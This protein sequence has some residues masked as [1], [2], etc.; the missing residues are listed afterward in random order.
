MPPAVELEVWRVPSA[1]IQ[2]DSVYAMLEGPPLATPGWLLAASVAGVQIAATTCLLLWVFLN[3]P[4]CTTPRFRE[5]RFDVVVA[6]EDAHRCVKMYNALIAS[7]AGREGLD[8]Q[9]IIELDERAAWRGAVH[10]MAG[11]ERCFDSMPQ[12]GPR[13]IVGRGV[14]GGVDYLELHQ[15][16]RARGPWRALSVAARRVAF[17]RERDR[18]VG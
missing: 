2:E 15:Q 8:Q 7:S 18:G 1:E 14:W 9:S 16:A 10:E 3:P 4:E 12:L 11:L 6:R 13:T 17:G 5:Q